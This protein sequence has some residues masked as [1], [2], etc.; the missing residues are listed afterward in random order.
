MAVKGLVVLAGFVVLAAVKTWP[1]VADFGRELGGQGSD[2]LLITWILS[3][4]VH[5][6]LA[7]PRGLFDAN[8]LHPI[9]R[10]LAF[11]EHMLGVVAFFAPAYLLTGNAVAGY[12]TLLLASFALSAFGAFALAWYW[13]R[14]WWP[15]IVAGI[16][17]GFS[18]LRFGQLGHLQVLNFFWAPWALIFLDRFL[19]RRRWADLAAFA[20]FYWLQVLASVYLAYMLTVAVVV[21]V[22]YH[23]IAVDRGLLGRAMVWPVAAFVAATLAVLLPTHLPYLWV[24]RAWQASWTP[25]ALA[26]YSAD[27]QSYLSAAPLVNDLYVAVFRPVTPAGSHERLLFPGLVPAALAAL[28]AFARVPGIPAAE[29]RRARWVFGLVA[30]VAFVLS[31]GPYL[32]LFGVNTRVPMP[33]LLLH[34]VVPGWSAMRVPARLAFLV[35]LACVPL[36]A[37]GA[38]VIAERALALSPRPAWRRAASPIVGLALAGLFLLELGAKPLPRQAVPTGRDVPEVYRWLGRERPGPIVEIPL[39]VP[40]DEHRYLY[41]STMHWLPIVNG[42]SGFAPSSHDEIKTILAELPGTRA[43]EYTAALGLAA[44]VVHGDRLPRESLARWAAAEETGRVRRLS[45][46]GSDVVYAVPPVALVSALRAQ[47]A[48]P[49]VLPADADVRLGLRLAPAGAGPW[50]HGRP[51]RVDEATVRWR[52]VATGHTVTSTMPVTLPLVVGAGATAAIQLRV[53]VPRAPGRYAVDVTLARHGLVTDPRTIEVSASR[54]LPTSAEARDQL[55]AEY[56]LDGGDGPR[57]MTLADSLHVRLT[58]RNAGGAV[59][60]TKPR[61]KKGEVALGWRWLTADGQ[62]LG[63]GAVP[64]RYDVY[65]GQRYEFDA[66]ITPAVEPGRYRLELGLVSGGV[67]PFAERGTAP[68]TVLVDVAPR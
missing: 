53:R 29:V 65:P 28:G 62:P 51:H 16:A 44:I 42:R 39:G 9:E 41:F 43:R 64:V 52:A 46:F 59:W 48:A 21:Y 32:V 35:G 63:G 15:S 12:N 11:S 38:R 55:A 3:W 58:A 57:A 25:G 45:G 13:T 5:A 49:D 68:V 31:L 17:F 1:L 10:S 24:Q 27:V 19:R 18:P 61:G 54:A 23:V 40:L 7:H 8:L 22:A 4:D 36:A 26:P 14:C 47:L 6:L 37:L 66:W 34:Y 60:L 2:A 67:G 30:A 56:A 33:Y 20:V 50:A